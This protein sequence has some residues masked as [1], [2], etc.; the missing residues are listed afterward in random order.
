L[1]G[2]RSLDFS[3]TQVTNNGMEYLAGLRELEEVAAGG[4]K[5]SGAGIRAFKLLPRLR[6]LDLGGM[7]KRN[8]GLWLVTL[9]DADMDVIAGLES[10]ESL[11]LADIKLTDLGAGKLKKLP[12]LRALNLSRTPVSGREFGGL[13]QLERLILWQ[14]KRLE[15]A[16]MAGIAALPK[17]AD[18]DL[19]ETAISDAGLATLQSAP[20]LRRLNLRGTKVTAAGIEAFHRARPACEVTVP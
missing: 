10:V 15:D 8:S 3:Y 11:D 16:Q 7:Q 19:S 2:L 14:T 6:V 1:T 17:L 18:L 20:A 12:R 9:T 13:K 5:I 4:N